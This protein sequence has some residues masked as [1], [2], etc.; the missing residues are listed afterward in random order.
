MHPSDFSDS[1]CDQHNGVFGRST[2]GAFIRDKGCIT[3]I[4]TTST[5]YARPYL[6]EK[7]IMSIPTLTTPRL[8]LR[9]FQ[10]SDIPAIVHLLQD[11]AIAQTTLHIPYPYSEEDARTWLRIQQDQLAQGRGYTFA[12]MQRE[13]DQLIGAIDIRLTMPHRRAE[14]GYWIGTPYWGQG[15]ATEAARAILRFGFEE[16][17]L[18]RISATHIVENPASG[19]VMEKIGMRYEGTLRQYTFHHGRFQDHRVYAILRREWEAMGH[20]G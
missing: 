19:R 20:D 1:C 10:S 14:I 15:Y 12:I 5:H 9:G 18:N 7:S 13:L 11:P 6:L 4:K 17:G 16:I 3:S 2:T 8:I